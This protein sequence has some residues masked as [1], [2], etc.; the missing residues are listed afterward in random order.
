MP[1]IFRLLPFAQP[2]EPRR[3]ARRARLGRFERTQ[4]LR[5]ALDERTLPPLPAQRQSKSSRCRSGNRGSAV[6]RCCARHRGARSIAPRNYPLPQ[7]GAL[8]RGGGEVV[9]CGLVKIEED[10]AGLF[11]V[12]T[13]VGFR[14]RGLGRAV[15]AALLAEAQRHGA[16]TAYLQVTADNAAAL[17]LY[18]RFGFAM[19]YDYWYRAREGEQH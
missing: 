13:A 8:V 5:A 14:G 4:V 15:V 6:A 12:H 7:A 18:R 17:A 16:R 10:H 9:A 3:V 1:A 19:A 2:A 11:A